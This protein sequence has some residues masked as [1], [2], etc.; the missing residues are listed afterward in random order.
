MFKQLQKSE[1]FL[2]E[3]P[4]SVPC[5][6]RIAG[7]GTQGEVLVEY[8]GYGPYPARMLVGI[9][10][11][12]LSRPRQRGRELLL[13]FEN[14][15]PG[16]PIIIG[17]MADPLEELISLEIAGE[18]TEEPRN[19]LIDGRQI[20]IEAEDEVVLKC[21]KGSIQIRKDG[22]IIIKGT[23]LLSRSSGPQRIRGASVNIN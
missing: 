7:A 23:D 6:G 20:V 14:G 16:K 2:T 17:L 8:N 3:S 10:S 12:E 1:E 22:K 9:S 11:S 4:F 19:V 13:V 15:D 5:I 21:G 18:K